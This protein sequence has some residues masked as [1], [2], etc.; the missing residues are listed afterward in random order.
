[1][2]EADDGEVAA[3]VFTVGDALSDALVRPGST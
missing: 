2:V 1:M 3:V